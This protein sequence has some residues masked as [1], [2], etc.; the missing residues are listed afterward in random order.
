MDN[1]I[2]LQSIDH[3]VLRA[4]A[5]PDML[6]FYQE[7]LG[8]TLERTLEDLGLYQLRAG[9]SLI[10]LVKERGPDAG[11]AKYVVYVERLKADGLHGLFGGLKRDQ[12]EGQLEKRMTAFLTAL[13]TE[14]R[15]A[16]AAA[17][18]KER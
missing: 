3:V 12:I 14:L 15:T 1:P 18:G 5:V 6:R 9:M 11:S 17:V 13:R 8:A 16:A 7:I 10:A 2:T 4:S